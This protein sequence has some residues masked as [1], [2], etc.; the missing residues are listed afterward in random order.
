M[1]TPPALRFTQAARRLGAAAHAAALIVPAFRCPPRLAGAQRTIRRY[2]GGPVI[3]VQVRGRPFFE[4]VADMVEGVIV[5]N[6]LEGEAAHRVRDC[7]AA[8]VDTIDDVP[9]RA[10]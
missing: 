6:R 7:L 2:P 8:V 4:V 5:A 1:D 10:A 9:A 3:A